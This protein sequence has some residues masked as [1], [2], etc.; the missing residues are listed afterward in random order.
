MAER[1]RRARP[2]EADAL[3]ALS[4]RSKASWGYPPALMRHFAED[5]R[6]TRRDVA[7]DETWVVEEG[8]SV[9]GVCRLRRGETA[10]LEDLWV[11]PSAMGRGVGRRLWEHVV[12]L[13]RSTGARA[14]ELDADPNATPFYERMGA[15]VI[16]E[17]PSSAIEGRTLPRMRCEVG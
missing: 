15:R 9:L 8:G 6:I 7:E 17:T 2:D 5:L 10:I 16:G 14:I 1:I 3:T 12:V 11:D 13:A 4:H